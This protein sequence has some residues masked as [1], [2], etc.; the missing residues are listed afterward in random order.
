MARWLGAPA[1]GSGN[2]LVVPSLDFGGEPYGDPRGRLGVEGRERVC[3]TFEGILERVARADLAAERM[4]PVSVLVDEGVSR[5]A[6]VGPG[7]KL[8]LV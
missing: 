2:R 4:L 7:P 6:E 5:G 3:V 8:G 1:D